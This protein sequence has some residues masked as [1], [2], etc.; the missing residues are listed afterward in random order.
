LD[1]WIKQFGLPHTDEM[2]AEAIWTLRLIRQEAGQLL[3]YWDSVEEVAKVLKREGTHEESYSYP[4]IFQAQGW[5][6]GTESIEEAQSRLREE[7]GNAVKEHA[8]TWYQRQRI[9]AS[10]HALCQQHKDHARNIRWLAQKQAGLLSMTSIARGD[11]VSIDTVRRGLQS[12]AKC[13]GVA[14]RYA[15]PGRKI[16]RST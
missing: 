12:A 8:G 13:L 4:F 7:F 6:P 5:K 9:G 16:P 11:E 14:I 1:Q 10:I 3:F 15:P 2:K